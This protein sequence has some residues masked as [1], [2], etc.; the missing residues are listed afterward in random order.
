MRNSKQSSPN[1]LHSFQFN[2]PS[3]KAAE[4]SQ[5]GFG[6]TIEEKEMIIRK[7]YDFR[8]LQL[9]HILLR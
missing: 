4:Q 6:L 8:T 5:V 1:N 9:S 7:Q 3:I 2:V